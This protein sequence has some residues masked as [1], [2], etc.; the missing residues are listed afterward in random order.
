M[1]RVVEP[2]ILDELP[3]QAPEAQVSRADLARVNR[4]MAHASLIRRAL[5]GDITRII[6]LGAGDGTLLLKAV[7]GRPVK[8]VVLV[9][10][11]RIVSEA[12]LQQFEKLNIEVEVAVIDVFQWLQEPR[13]P[14]PTAIIANL[15]L[16]HFKAPELEKLLT[17][18]AA[19]CETFIACEP[20]RG[21]WPA[22][23]AS[24]LGVIGCNRVTRHDARISVRAGFSG[25]EL[26]A[27]WPDSTTW[28]VEEREAGLFSHLFVAQRL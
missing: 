1:A 21:V 18:A 13:A 8:H 12:T 2:E 6:D 19:R 5:P 10:R 25:N 4:I 16:H 22:F 27:L 11:Q 26:T 3:A 23:A 9:D 15:F 14:E 20:R 7:Q 17:L 24:L 28:R